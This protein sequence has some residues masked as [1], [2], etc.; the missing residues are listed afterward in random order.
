MFEFK[1]GKI[2]LILL[3]FACNFSFAQKG[4]NPNEKITTKKNKQSEFSIKT[5]NT[6]NVGWGFDIY[7]KGKM[8][9]HQPHI[10]A[11]S[12]NKGFKTEIEAKKIGTL[13]QK[14]I[15]KNIMPPTIEIKELDSLKIKY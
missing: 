9:I 12:G 6:A 14:K 13:M 10:P 2:I 4:T 7:Q 11:I 1:K 8:L 15:E 3:L 5:Y